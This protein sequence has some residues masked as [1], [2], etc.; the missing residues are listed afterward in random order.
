MMKMMMMML[1]RQAG[2]LK[3]SP[4][5]RASEL[6]ASKAPGPCSWLELSRRLPGCS[7]YGRHDVDFTARKA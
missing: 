1:V 4:G 7:G 6:S 5:V 2:H 3:A